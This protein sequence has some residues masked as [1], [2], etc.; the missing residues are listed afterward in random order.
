MRLSTARPW[1]E[2]C[3]GVVRSISRRGA[4]V[5]QIT[6]LSMVLLVVAVGCVAE[7]DV[8]SEQFELEGDGLD[9]ALTSLL[10]SNGF[11]GTIE[12]QLEARLGRPINEDAAEV[13]RLLFFD[14]ILS[15]HAAP[16]DD[17]AGNPCAGCHDPGYAFGDSQRIAIGVDSNGIVGVDRHGPRNQRRAPFSVNAV[18]YPALMWTPRFFA[19]SGDPFDNSG[20][21]VFP[22][23]A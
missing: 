21:F 15:L 8:A 9:D 14:K 23:A 3:S 17:A 12:S 19:V 6:T 5:R 7:D 2:S 1:T 10:V 4:A 16:G 20:G 18:F 11:T 13:G 22:A